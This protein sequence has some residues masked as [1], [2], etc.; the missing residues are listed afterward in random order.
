MHIHT[1]Q[2][3]QIF[4]LQCFNDKTFKI[5]GQPSF[6]CYPTHMPHQVIKAI[7]LL[8][9]SVQLLKFPLILSP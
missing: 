5:G 8:L 9:T 7:S 2:C 6:K 1:W 3:M 4:I